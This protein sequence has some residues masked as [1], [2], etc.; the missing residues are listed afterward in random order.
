MLRI[1]SACTSE[2]LNV[3]HQHRLRLVLGADDLDDLVEVE[4]GDQIA[5]EHFQTVLD[6]LEPVF[7]TPQQHV[8][9]MIEP[10]AQRFGEAD[11][12]AECGR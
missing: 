3:F 1:A 10:R 4:I 5:A 7:R 12:L 2:S 9:P 8:A 11:D 6:L